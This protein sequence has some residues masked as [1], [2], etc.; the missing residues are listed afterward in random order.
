M[1]VSTAVNRPRG[2]NSVQEL[3]LDTDGP[4]TLNTT[5]TSANQINISTGVVVTTVSNALGDD[6]PKTWSQGRRGT[7]H[8]G[9]QPRH[10]L[11]CCSAWTAVRRGNA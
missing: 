9:H 5:A 2:A 8:H 4:Y 7:S 11:H 10:R 6:Q 3:R 1:A